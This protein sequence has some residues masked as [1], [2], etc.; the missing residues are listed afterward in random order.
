[1]AGM[2]QVPFGHTSVSCIQPLMPA[3]AYKTYGMAMPLAT[4]W[5]PSTCEEAGCEHYR[6]GWVSTFDLATDLGVK[7]H[8][9]CKADRTRSFHIQ[10]AG[11]TLVKFVYK[12]GNR[13]FRSGDHRLPLERPARFTVRGGD[14]RGNPRG[15][16]ARVHS[17]ATDWCEDF[18]EHQDRIAAAI[19]KG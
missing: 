13:C 16:P 15:V 19:Q 3:H 14:F 6:H 17:S 18:A 9:Y 1:M 4:H 5:R 10:R 8:D 12:P 7:Q 11:L 2:I